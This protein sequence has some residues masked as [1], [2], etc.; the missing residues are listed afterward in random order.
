LQSFEA[1]RNASGSFSY[2]AP[3]G[4]HDDMVMALAIAWNAV[5]ASGPLVLW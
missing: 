5:S 1:K 4:L 3:T 2:S